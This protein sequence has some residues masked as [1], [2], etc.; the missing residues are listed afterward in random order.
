MGKSV[1]ANKFP[2]FSSSVTNLLYENK[3]GVFT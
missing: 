1:K 3:L 2:L